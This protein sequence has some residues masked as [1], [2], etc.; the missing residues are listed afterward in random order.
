[1]LSHDAVGWVFQDVPTG[2]HKNYLTQMRD[3]EALLGGMDHPRI[4]EMVVL[5]DSEF[6]NWP[7]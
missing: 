6:P 4:D 1:M 5:L 7:T 2:K 3:D